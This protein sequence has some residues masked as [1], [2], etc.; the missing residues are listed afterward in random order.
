MM[1]RRLREETGLCSLGRC[2]FCGLGLRGLCEAETRPQAVALLVG[3]V[4]EGYLGLENLY[5]QRIALE[6][7]QSRTWEV[8]VLIDCAGFGAR[9]FTP[10][11]N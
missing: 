7:S 11:I 2:W 6:G 10:I 4:M 5:G 1:G 9:D 8:F 3:E